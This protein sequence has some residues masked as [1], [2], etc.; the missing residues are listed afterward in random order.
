VVMAIADPLERCKVSAIA[1]ADPSRSLGHHV[2]AFQRRPAGRVKPVSPRRGASEARGLD[3][4]EERR[5]IRSVMARA[6][7]GPSPRHDRHSECRNRGSSVVRAPGGA[8]M[9]KLHTGRC[10]GVARTG[11]GR[12]NGVLASQVGRSDRSVHEHA[13][14]VWFK[15][16]SRAWARRWWKDFAEWMFT[17]AN[18]DRARTAPGSACA[19]VGIAHVIQP[20]GEKVNFHQH[21][22][23]IC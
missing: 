8:V 3:A 23:R 6:V 1:T 4:A 10:G 7:S 13:T 17:P 14:I 5:T 18:A 20:S 16:P 9:R 21:A 19:S 2:I 15:R 22:R 12:R 11:H